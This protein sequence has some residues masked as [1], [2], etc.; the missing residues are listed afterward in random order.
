MLE[1]RLKIGIQGKPVNLIYLHSLLC[2][3]ESVSFWSRVVFVVYWGWAGAEDEGKTGRSLHMSKIVEKKKKEKSVRN[4][5]NLST[6]L[7]FAPH[8]TSGHLKNTAPTCTSSITHTQQQQR[9]I[10]HIRVEKVSL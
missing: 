5:D 4:V 2:C 6:R 1:K 10:I 7:C 8:S 3:H 9:H